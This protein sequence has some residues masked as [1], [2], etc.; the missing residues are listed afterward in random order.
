[1]VLTTDTNAAVDAFIDGETVTT[2]TV[3]VTTLA[4]DE[5][6]DVVTAA[7]AAI[8]P[9]PL[10]VVA[11]PEVFEEVVAPDVVDLITGAT[12]AVTTVAV[13]LEVPAPNPLADVVEFDAVLPTAATTD[14]DAFITDESDTVD[15]STAV[16]AEDV[17]NEAG[18][19]LVGVSEEVATEGDDI[20]STAE[21]F[22]P[23][24]TG[25]VIPYGRGAKQHIIWALDEDLAPV[26]YTHL[27]LPTKRIV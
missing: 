26:S 19:A 22:V 10:T 2:P 1:M 7:R 16:L 8:A 14:V 11:V 23:V 13:V 4:A 5:E 15:K 6:L 17:S 12:T 3:V 21:V 18:D 20:T 25:L 27:T 9:E 24:V